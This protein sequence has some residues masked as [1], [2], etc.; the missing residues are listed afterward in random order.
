MEAT[1]IYRRYPSPA[2]PTP[3]LSPISL[4]SFKRDNRLPAAFAYTQW[5]IPQAIQN[6]DAISSSSSIVCTPRHVLSCQH[7]CF[8]RNDEGDG[9]MTHDQQRCGG[10]TRMGGFISFSC[11]QNKSI[12]FIWGCG[13]VGWRLGWMW[14][15]EW[16]WI[17]MAISYHST[18]HALAGLKIIV[19]AKTN[20]M[21][22]HSWT[23]HTQQNGYSPN[24]RPR[25]HSVQ[26][27]RVKTPQQS[28][29]REEAH[30]L[31]ATDK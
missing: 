27:S 11:S 28:N 30:D 15:D 18:C 29:W 21:N 3:S 19:V 12:R 20:W 8:V 6:P 17:A 9:A 7:A 31:N 22:R 13:R 16:N 23:E 1:K 10:R 24:H 5:H 2:H 14:N 26:P 4:C 25:I